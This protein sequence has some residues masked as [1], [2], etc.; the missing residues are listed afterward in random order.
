MI[1]NISDFT[2][3]YEIHRGLYDQSKLQDYID[4]YEKRY[5]IHL[6]GA[7]LYNEFISDLDPYFVP[8]SPNFLQVF[9]SFELDS[10]IMLPN[11]ILIS[12]GIKQMLKGFIYFE[13]LK[14]TTNQTTPNGLV[15]PSNENST[16]ATTLY[17]MMYTRYNEAVRTYR[18]IQYY[19]ITNYNLKGGAIMQFGV[20][21]YGNGYLNPNVITTTTGGSGNGF[22]VQYLTDPSSNDAITE[23]FIENAGVDYSF[24]DEIVIDGWTIF[25][26]TLQIIKVSKGYFNTFN[27]VQKSMVYWL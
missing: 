5:L 26:C 15:I 6:F 19:I 3:K 12:E 8:E 11:E 7:T 27:G 4:I 14:D 13:Y 2:G 17:S 22:T 24:M 23:I 16:T 9:K 1:V 20:F 10:N 18:A 21:N 25:P